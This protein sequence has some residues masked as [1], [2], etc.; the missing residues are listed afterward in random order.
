MG[1]SKT[2]TQKQH[3]GLH[4]GLVSKRGFNQAEKNHNLATGGNKNDLTMNKQYTQTKY[5]MGK[6]TGGNIEGGARYSHRRKQ[7]ERLSDP[8]SYV[9]A[10]TRETGAPS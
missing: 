6:Y 3:T 8:G 1:E 2:W 5:T 4:F 9:V 7:S 10:R